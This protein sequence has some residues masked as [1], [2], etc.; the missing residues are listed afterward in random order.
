MSVAGAL[1]HSWEGLA[2]SG[3]KHHMEERIVLEHI[4]RRYR[5]SCSMHELAEASPPPM[6]NAQPTRKHA[7]CTPKP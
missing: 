1:A 6:L 2:R 4:T 7:P 5:T 3:R